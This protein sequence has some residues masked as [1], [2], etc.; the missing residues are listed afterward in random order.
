M[1]VL[2]ALK[3]PSRDHVGR[4]WRRGA[5]K[6][7][8]LVSERKFS[9]ASALMIIPDHNLQGGKVSTPRDVA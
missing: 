1:H 3:E 6:C 4:T 9:N 5:D 7:A 8:H 2:V